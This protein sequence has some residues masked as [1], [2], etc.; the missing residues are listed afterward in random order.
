MFRAGGFIAPPQLLQHL[1]PG[2]LIHVF[3]HSR[4]G[5]PT[6]GTTNHFPSPTHP[7]RVTKLLAQFERESLHLIILQ[8]HDVFY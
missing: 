1:F 4:H 8:A 5:N 2:R 3:I 6:S 7:A